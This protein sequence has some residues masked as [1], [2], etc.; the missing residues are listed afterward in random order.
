VAVALKENALREQVTDEVACEARLLD[1]GFG[2][3]AG[4][5]RLSGRHRGAYE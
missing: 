5:G 2:C 1:D 4:C 3:R